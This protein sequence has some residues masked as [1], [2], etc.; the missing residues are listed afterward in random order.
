VHTGALPLGAKKHYQTMKS[1][2]SLLFPIVMILGMGSAFDPLRAQIPSAASG[3][4][5]PAIIVIRHAED[6][7]EWVNK[8]E[9][10]FEGKPASNSKPAEDPWPSELWKAEAG[11]W[12]EYHHTFVFIDNSGAIRGAD[13]NGFEIALHGLSGNWRTSGGKKGTNMK[14]NKEGPLGEKQAVSLGEHLGS[15]LEKGK[16][17]RIN[18]AI[19]M[20]PREENA[21]PNPF[22]TLWPYIKRRAVP[23]SW[24]GWAGCELYLVQRDTNSKDKWP[25]L[26]ALIDKDEILAT[27]EW[28]S[29][30]ICWTGEGLQGKDGILDKLIRKYRGEGHNYWIN[31][32]TER[33]ADIFV[34][35]LDG[36]GRGVAEKWK[37]DYKS[38]GFELLETHA[39][40]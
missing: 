40:E 35:Y 22:D 11:P 19:T 1:F 20:D 28:G 4:T 6:A 38:G 14:D 12:P 39:D 29:T 24:G 30:I 18:R 34:F 25:G 5:R 23:N 21:T 32:P 36:N 15:L 2:R 8:S 37:F 31:G 9:K 13:T 3:G 17:A 27:H 10:P 7:L 33:C 26:M 16:F